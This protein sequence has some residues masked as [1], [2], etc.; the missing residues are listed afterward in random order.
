VSIESPRDLAGLRAAGA[1]VAETLEAARRCVAS[2]VTTA[3]IDAVA[4]E[5]FARP[6]ARSA[7]NATYG[8]PGTICISLDD[9]AVHGVPGPRRLAPGDLV[10]LDVTAEV[11]GYVA[12][13]AI[14]VS[15]PP[16]RPQ[17]ERLAACA[18][19]ALA[20]GIRRARAGRPL[21]AIGAAV[22]PEVERWGYSVLRNLSGHGVGR[23]I[24]EEPTVPNYPAPGLRQPLTDGLVITVEPI[25]AASGR[26]VTPS[27]DGWT[28]RSADGSLSAHAEHTI[29]VTR[30]EPIVLT[31]V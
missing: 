8:F 13:A 10:K 22:E 29:V 7:P 17:A 25:I 24:H 26:R 21:N 31:G 28:I 18:R 11:D 1:V 5:V 3:E 20:L 30:G 6:G 23:R 27:S 14:S 16:A 15:V 4:A 2:G 9:E 12:D 19:A